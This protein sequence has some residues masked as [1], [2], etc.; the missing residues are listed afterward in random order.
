[1]SVVTLARAR[2]LYS[3][4]TITRPRRLDLLTMNFAFEFR[5]PFKE[6]FVNSVRFL[7]NNFRDLFSIG[8]LVQENVKRQVGNEGSCEGHTLNGDIFE[9]GICQD[10]SHLPRRHIRVLLTIILLVSHITQIGLVLF[11]SSLWKV[12]QM[13][14][15][16]R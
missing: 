12:E 10:I 9:G 1:M 4:I 11:L 3:T 15:T 5:V 6:K 2:V 14:P 16:D 8:A 7:E 13:S